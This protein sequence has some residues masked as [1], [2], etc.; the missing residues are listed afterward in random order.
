MKKILINLGQILLIDKKDWKIIRYYSWRTRWDKKRNCYTC[1]M[2]YINKKQF[3]G[4]FDKPKEAS[5]IYK[6]TKNSYLQKYG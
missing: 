3:L 2:A 1:P 4:Y 5:K 6:K